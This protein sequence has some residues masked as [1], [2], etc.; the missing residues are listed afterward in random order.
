MDFVRVHDTHFMFDAFKV[1]EKRRRVSDGT[2]QVLL[3]GSRIFDSF[4]FYF[5]FLNK[6]IN[7]VKFFCCF[8]VFFMREPYLFTV[9][10]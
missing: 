5:L 8:A 7:D 6:N 3:C 2:A 9:A 1:D 4:I 10:R